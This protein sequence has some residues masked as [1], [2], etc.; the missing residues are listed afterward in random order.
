MAREIRR[1]PVTIPANT[2][3]TANFTSDLSFPDRAVE[4]IEIRVPPGPR[5]E[6]GFALGAAGQ[7]IIPFQAGQFIVTDDETIHWPLED[8]HD[9]GSWTFFGYNTG[10]FPHTI[11]VRFLLKVATSTG[12]AQAPVAPL[13]LGQAPGSSPPSLAPLPPLPPLPAPII[14]GG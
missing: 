13:D 4:E 12:Q 2:A 8:Q 10:Q 14:G 7:Q 6:V 1:F 3:K 5:G 11:E 9:S